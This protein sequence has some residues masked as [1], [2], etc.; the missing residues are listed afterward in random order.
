LE[1]GFDGQTD[2]Y[3]EELDKRLYKT[4]PQHFNT[5][6][7]RPVQTVA[8]PTRQNSKGRNARNKVVR[9]NQR[10]VAIANK[11]GVSLEDYAKHVKE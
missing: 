5:A 7:D 4:F 11:L 6:D 8:S 3:Y 9:L 1:E 2:E 10:Q